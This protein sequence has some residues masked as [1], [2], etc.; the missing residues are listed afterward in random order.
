MT[1]L[2]IVT[3]KNYPE[4]L[5]ILLAH[6]RIKINNTIKIVVRKIGDTTEIELQWTAMTFA[7]FADNSA[8]MSRLVQVPELDINYQDDNGYTAA[9]YASMEHRTECVRILAETGKVDW[10]KRDKYGRTP[11]YLR[12]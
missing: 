6:H 1:G 10:N 7:C 8:I 4:L 2:T 5:Q 3:N 11:L 9:H 12:L